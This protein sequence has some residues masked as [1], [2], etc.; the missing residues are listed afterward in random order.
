MV[1]NIDFG[2]DKFGSAS[3]IILL[4]WQCYLSLLISLPYYKMGLI[5]QWLNKIIFIIVI[6]I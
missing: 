4:T 1:K 3:L 6:I 5:K 2:V